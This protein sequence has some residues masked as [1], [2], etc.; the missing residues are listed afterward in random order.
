MTIAGGDRRAAAVCA[1]LVGLALAAVPG[2]DDPVH[3]VVISIDGLMPATYTQPGPARVPTLRKLAAEGAYATGVVGVLP[4]LTYPSHTTLITGVRPAVHGILDNRIVDPEGR[5]NTAWYWYAQ[6]IRV[7]T[8]PGAARARGLRAAAVNWPATVGLEID[9]LIPEYWRSDHPETLK[10]LRALSIPR[11]LFDVI[12]SGA[13]QALTWPIDD[14]ERTDAAVVVLTKFRPHVL[15]L[16]LVAV[17]TAQH[18]F[19][20]GSPEALEALE[21]TDALVAKVRQA[22]IDAGIANRTNLAIVSDHGFLPIGKQLQ[23]NAVLKQQQLVTTNARGAITGWQAYFHPS[24]GSGYVYLKN[25]SDAATAGRV[26]ELL[27]KLAANPQ[28]GIEKVW[29]KEDLA[30]LGAHPDASFGIEMRPGFYTALG[31]DNAMA[32]TP[33][34]GGHGFDPARPELRASFIATGPAFKGRGSLGLIRMTQIAPTLARL[35][36][37]SLSPSADE[38]I[39]LGQ[40][41][42]LG[43]L[44]G[45][46]LAGWVGRQ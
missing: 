43:Q 29:T 7:P 14:D 6:D 34:R 10:V 45:V 3:V 44:R 31:T 2:A 16:H 15:L 19:G 21:R 22:V 46:G 5:S 18:D 30:R 8:L 20:P 27:K 12:G 11:D 40:V 13:G 17:D 23:L 24:G 25:P 37:V 32:N 35:L 4:S 1:L 26:H 33:D 41:G 36:G 9:Y 39:V 38:P 42:L 28:Y